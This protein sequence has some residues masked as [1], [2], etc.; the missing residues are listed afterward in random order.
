MQ[1]GEAKKLVKLKVRNNIDFSIYLFFAKYIDKHTL[2]GGHY[3]WVWGFQVFSICF[4]DVIWAGRIP[5]SIFF[6]MG[7]ALLS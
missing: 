7:S 2:I 5:K 4:C 6:Q 3:H 1:A